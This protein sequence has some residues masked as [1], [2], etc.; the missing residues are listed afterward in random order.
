MLFVLPMGIMG[1]TDPARPRAPRRAV[2]VLAGLTCAAGVVV[3]AP[4]QAA[5]DPGVQK[6]KVDSRIDRLEDHLDDTSAKLKKSYTALKSTQAQ[7][8]GAREALQQAEAAAAEADR[9][10]TVAAQELEV[11]RA[12]EKKARAELERTT[13]E[14]EDG[15]AKLAQFAAQIYQEQG[16]GQLDVAL[17]STDPQ[18]FADRIA[19][20]DTV[21]DVQ[22]QTMEHLATEQASQRALEDHLS[23]LRADSAVKK[24]AAEEALAK[25]EAARRVAADAKA[26]LEALAASQEQQTAD[27]EDQ[28]AADKKQLAAM[29]AEQARLQKI[30]EERAAEARRRAAEA[31]RKKAAAEAAARKKAQQ[32]KASRSSGGG[33]S[34]GGSSPSGGSSS[35]SS[36]LS[37]PVRSGW[38]SSEFGNRYH[39]LLHIWRLHAGRDYAANCGTPVYAAA[40]GTV[41]MAGPTYGYGNRIVID[42]GLQ[43]GVGLATTYNHLSG[44]AVGGGGV[45]RGQLI[46]YVGSTGTSTGCH[47]HFETL[48]NGSFADPRRWL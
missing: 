6:R 19:L 5:S 48:E 16:F 24:K 2:A 18:Q 30:L 7:I 31:A 29:R 23:A 14:V 11:A 28:V 39:P 40:S 47:L 37:A 9:A 26:R 20:V 45:S 38:V 22:G 4:A 17:S 12:N 13:K 35:S 42:H 44:F 32:E 8:P 41:I 43:R 15:R 27:F 36:Y 1:R 25:A 10:N 21:M 46:G 3:P 34:S 33:T